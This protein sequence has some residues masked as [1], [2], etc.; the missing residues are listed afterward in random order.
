MRAAI[1]KYH[2]LGGLTTAAYFLTNL[3]IK[4]SAELVS[5]KMISLTRRWSIFSQHLYTVFTLG[6]PRVLG[7]PWWFRW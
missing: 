5:F 3:V 7:L 4:V 1:T 2:R 6:V